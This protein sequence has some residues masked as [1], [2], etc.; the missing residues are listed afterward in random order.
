MTHETLSSSSMGMIGK[1]ALW[2]FVRIGLPALALLV[3]ADLGEAEV[4]SEVALEE[5]LVDA[6]VLV[7]EA[8]ADSAVD[9]AAVEAVEV[10]AAATL[11]LLLAGLREAQVEPQF[12][13]IL[14]PTTQLQ[15][16]REARL[17][18]SEM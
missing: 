6:A 18:T 7:L 16:P 11:D 14:S 9:L 17:F 15:A 1:A 12:H 13:P 4:V 8:V 5:A 2:K 3:A 10:S